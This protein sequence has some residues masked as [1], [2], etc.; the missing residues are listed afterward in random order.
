MKGLTHLDPEGRP[1]MV[2]VSDKARTLRRAVAA[3]YLELG[4]ACAHALASG[5]WPK[6]DPWTVTRLGAING[7]KRTAELS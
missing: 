3:G 4:P 6:G 2:D 1:R 5:S 7:V